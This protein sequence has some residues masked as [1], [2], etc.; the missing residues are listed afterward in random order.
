[1]T[2]LLASDSLAEPQHVKVEKIQT[3]GKL[4]LGIIND[5]LDLSKIEADQLI[6]EELPFDVNAVLATVEAFRASITRPTVSLNVI[7]PKWL[8]H[9]PLP[10]LIGDQRRIEQVLA[11]L[12]SNAVKFTEQGQISVTFDLQQTGPS[13]VQ[14]HVTIQDTGMGIAPEFMTHL[15]TPFTQSDTG[16]ARQYGGTGL[17]LS[18]SKQ[19]VELM[20]GQIHVVSQPGQ[21]STFWFELP[22]S[23]DAKTPAKVQRLSTEAPTTPNR[24]TGL[25]MLVVDDS[26]SI[27]DL[28]MEF[29][30]REGAS[31]ELA[32]DGAQALTILLDQP[33]AFDC[34]MM[35]V[36]MPVMD[37]L[38]ATKNIR[39]L[40]Q[41]DP[42][43][44]LAMTAGL[45]AEQ[46][47]RARQAG[48]ADV[49]AKP[50][51]ANRMIAQILTAVGRSNNHADI[52][53]PHHPNPMPFI[54][55]IDR[56]HANRIMDGNCR[57]F[58]RLITVFVEEFAG[59]DDR[60][61]TML[62]HGI[63]PDMLKEAGRLVHA[64]KGAASQIGADE[65]CQAAAA[66]EHA[67]LSDSPHKHVKLDAMGKLLTDL[68]ASLKRHLQGLA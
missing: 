3:A 24:L 17:G 54:A 13:S 47:A 11:N 32:V 15:F 39:A 19:L 28:I 38:T 60:I 64:L 46:Q 40:R 51:D 9:K 14:L 18:I 41:F 21:G 48:M 4:L 43:P 12:L 55:G 16:I 53:A 37:G 61:A 10:L 44:V 36:Q 66:V 35:D 42:L 26:P 25:R 20:G 59:L 5:I 65:I 23:I 67:L 34:V 2:D 52:T 63:N 68:I 22:L 31:V 56:E 57:L 62:A 7:G 29:L 33:H 6:T 58:D 1:L 27:R 49:V 8:G 45:L 30:Q 50:I